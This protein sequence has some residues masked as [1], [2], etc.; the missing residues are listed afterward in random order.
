MIVIVFTGN[1]VFKRI[2]ILMLY[3]LVAI[4]RFREFNTVD[5]YTFHKYRVAFME[6]GI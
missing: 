5:S 1:K 3:S 6:K 4:A 2:G